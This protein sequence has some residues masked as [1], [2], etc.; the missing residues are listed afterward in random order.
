MQL[1][2]LILTDEYIVKYGYRKLAN[3]KKREK[4]TS[5]Y[6]YRVMVRGCPDFIQGAVFDTHKK[7]Y[8]WANWNYK[9]ASNYFKIIRVFV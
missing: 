4:V 5:E 2:D 8:E 7:A 3:Y 6:A 9:G 1:T